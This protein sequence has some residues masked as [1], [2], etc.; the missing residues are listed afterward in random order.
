[1]C[2]RDSA[3]TML[4]AE[5]LDLGKRQIRFN[6][7]SKHLKVWLKCLVKSL[8]LGSCQ[9]FEQFLSHIRS[10]VSMPDIGCHVQIY[11]GKRKLLDQIS[12][13]LIL[14]KIVDVSQCC[15]ILY[16]VLFSER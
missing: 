2:I 1:M 16:S 15:V 7:V 13:V 10:G 6:S 5:T 9:C 11:D 12:L 8:H 14:K 3:N 4:A